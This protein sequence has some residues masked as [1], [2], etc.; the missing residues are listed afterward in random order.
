M[1]AKK[2]EAAAKKKKWRPCCD[3]LTRGAIQL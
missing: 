2:K 1:I 3:I